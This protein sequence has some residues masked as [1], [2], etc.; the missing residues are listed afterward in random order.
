MTSASRAEGPRFDSWQAHF[1]IKKLIILIFMSDP[2]EKNLTLV[3]LRIY[4]MK[5]GF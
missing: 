5:K 3:I 2:Y 1:L 4:N